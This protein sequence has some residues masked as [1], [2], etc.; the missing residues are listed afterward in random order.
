MKKMTL[1]AATL[2]LGSAPRLVPI[3]SPTFFGF[4][5][6]TGRPWRAF[7]LAVCKLPLI[8]FLFLF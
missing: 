4:T 8:L 7:I 1:E 3:Q 6:E 5:N 2:L